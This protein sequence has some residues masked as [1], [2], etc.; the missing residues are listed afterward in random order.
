MGK[1]LSEYIEV[2]SL[3][4]S[5]KIPTIT[6]NGNEYI[7]ASNLMW[8]SSEEASWCYD[9]INGSKIK[10]YTKYFTGTLDGDSQTDILHGVS[11]EDNILAVTCMCK[12]S[13]GSYEIYDFYT[14]ANTAYAF[15]LYV[16]TS[17]ISVWGVGAQLQGQNYR[18]KLEYKL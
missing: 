17:A 12:N 8:D 10:V 18:I 16:M 4:A 11:D 15:Q 5:D 9:N 6:E 1:K 3:T 14:G 13:S 2:S 7:H